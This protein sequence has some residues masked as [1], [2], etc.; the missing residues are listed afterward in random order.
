[1]A[2]PPSGAT[3]DPTPGHTGRP[4]VLVLGGGFGGV[5]AARKLANADVDVTVVDKNDYH[6]FQPL[7]YQ[8]A[9]D[10]LE[11]AAC[12]H[13]LRDLFHE[14]PNVAVHEATVTG[15]DLDACEVQ[16]AEM[17]PLTY[18][19]LVLGLGAAVNFFGVEGAGEH[20][21][22][23]YTLADALRLKDHV[24]RRW[25]AADRDP[26][27]VEAGAVN[28]VVVGGG[29]TGIESAGALAELYRSNFSQDYPGIRQDQARIVLV[30]AG[31][32]LMSMFKAD[33]RS[34]TRKA[35]EKRGVEVLLGEVV[36]SVEPTRVT[37][38][39]GKVIEAQTLV[40]GAG[41]Q[42]SPI[43]E[44]LGVELQ[45]G[46][47]VP[48]EPDLSVAGHPEVFAVGDIAWI[49][50]AKTNDVLPQLGSVALQAGEHAGGNIARL[51]AGKDAEP[52]EY[53]DKG[54]MATIGR[55][56]AVIQT[57]GGHTL[58]GKGA[59]LAWGAVHLALLS[60]GEDRAKAVVDWTWAGF[61]HERPGRISV[62][63]DLR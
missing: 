30:E 22:P 1:M 31:S 24:L 61:T 62:R 39:S 56:T 32:A 44:V 42:A 37:L 53:H 12:G 28:V 18:H 38:Q 16:F 13:P 3:S 20:A 35:L 11:T 2:P 49:T 23:M 52:F 26:A 6:T 25:E 46:N 48:V 14:Q 27:L 15:I 50:D 7:L 33:I 41:L 51:V 45:H 57:R 34:Y 29:P 55:G 19:Y 36:A 21:F 10:L 59:F 63:T 4:Q 5:G 60:T 9:T 54:T 8:V 43:V 17:P 47:R 58:K 40:W